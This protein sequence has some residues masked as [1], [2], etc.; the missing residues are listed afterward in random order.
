MVQAVT[1]TTASRCRAG[2]EAGSPR[3][4]EGLEAAAAATAA[5][6]FGTSAA[7]C[8]SQP[9]GC[10]LQR[11]ACQARMVRAAVP[12]RFRTWLEMPEAMDSTWTAHLT[13]QETPERAT[14]A[15]A[16]LVDVCRTPWDDPELAGATAAGAGASA[17]AAPPQTSAAPAA[18][19]QPAAFVPKPAVPISI[20][21][22]RAQFDMQEAE[23]LLKR[24]QV[25]GFGLA[26]VC[27]IRCTAFDSKLLAGQRPPNSSVS[28]TCVQ[29]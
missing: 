27:C 14:C 6:A 21:K 3:E 12:K 11:A 2:E 22:R 24:E 25:R 7:S 26:C 1:L 17:P 23:K 8:S 5:G 29:V 20:A 18:A 10:A 28:T 16:V 15:S 13:V 19:A 9:G 4:A